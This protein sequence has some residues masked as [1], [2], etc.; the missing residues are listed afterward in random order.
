ML[1]LDCAISNPRYDSQTKENL[2]TESKDFKTTYTPSEKFIKRII[3]SGIIQNILDAAAAQEEMERMRALRSKQKDMDR[4]DY[5]RV[6]K[7]N[8][9]HEKKERHK[10]VLFLSEGDSAAK[11]VQGGRGNNARYLGSFALK[12]KPLNVREKEIERILGLKKKKGPDDEK[13]KEKPSVIQNILTIMGLRIGEKVESIHQL[14][15]G[16]VAFTT[17]ADVDGSHISGLLI[18]LFDQFWPELFDLGVIHIFRT[19][20]VKVFV[21]GKTVKQFFTER[22][23]KDWEHAEGE[24]L[25]GWS[26]KYYKG[27]GTS[28]DKEFTEYL[29][30]MEEYLFRL[31]VK[32]Q[33]DRDAI[34]L[35]FNGQ[36]ADD[37]KVWLE[38]PAANFEDYVIAA[39]KDRTRRAGRGS[40]AA[41]TGITP[42][43]RI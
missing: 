22:E 9:A 43:Q 18:N 5:R 7:F 25:K 17:D 2:I 38:T 13:K 16:K 14:N 32:T 36:R 26:H 27:L 35:A 3:N 11:A 24:K 1:F 30:N 40:E 12:G 28:S 33:E 10:C 19:P 6:D 39:E 4:A 20:L 21:K 23:F 31:D 15:F 41:Q 29:D 34:D 42:F 37:R 8:D